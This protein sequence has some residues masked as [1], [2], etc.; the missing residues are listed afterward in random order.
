[1]V[2][3]EDTIVR[4]FAPL[5]T[6]RRTAFLEASAP[7]AV[8]SLLAAALGGLVGHW[9][10]ASGGQSQKLPWLG[11]LLPTAAGLAIALLVIGCAMPPV[12]RST[13]TEETRFE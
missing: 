5:P 12:R 8:L 13:N 11:L 10:V 6:L 3:R 1:M 4:P 9:T 7:L 2:L